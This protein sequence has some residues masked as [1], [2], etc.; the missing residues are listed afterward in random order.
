MVKMMALSH[1]MRMLSRTLLGGL[2]LWLVGCSAFESSS[3]SGAMS[4]AGSGVEYLLGAE[5]VLAIAVWKDEHLTKEVVVRPDGFISFPLVG[6]VQAAGRT[7][8]EVRADIAKRLAKYIPNPNVSVAAVKVL[9]YRIYVLGRVNKPG[10]FMIGHTTDVLQALSLAGG[11]TPFASENDIRIIRRIHG[12]QQV[13][14]VPY[15]DLKRG[16]SLER[17]ALLQRGDVVMVP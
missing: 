10:E 9:S 15:G 17:N 6:E 11:L 12:E 7:V 2:L 4:A 5:D 3:K 14:P 13:I 16:K 8:E 1:V